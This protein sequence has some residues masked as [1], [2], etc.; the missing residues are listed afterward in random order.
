MKF[1]L[2]LLI[3]PCIGYSQVKDYEL[4]LEDHELEIFYRSSDVKN[5]NYNE[6]SEYEKIRDINGNF[7]IKD[8]VLVIYNSFMDEYNMVHQLTQNYEILEVIRVHYSEKYNMKQWLIKAIDTK[9]QVEV[10]IGFTIGYEMS[11]DEIKLIGNQL[12]YELVIINIIKRY[13]FIG[14]I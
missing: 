6:Y 1:L 8:S 12:K 7:T 11:N 5:I 2:F 13:N 10:A 9:L 3:I 4:S 14:L